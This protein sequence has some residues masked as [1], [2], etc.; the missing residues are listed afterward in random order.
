MKDLIGN[1]VKP[2]DILLEI[3]RGGSFGGGTSPSYSMKLWQKPSS[4]DGSGY[5]YDIDGTRSKFWW[6]SVHESI[7]IDMSTMPD[8]FEYSFKHG[9]S[10]LSSSIKNGTINELIETSNWNERRIIPS[11]VDGYLRK[12]ELKLSSIDDIKKNIG[13]LSD[14]NY[15]PREVMVQVMRLVGAK[16]APVHNGEIGLASMYDHFHYWAII[17]QFKKDTTLR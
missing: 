12:K 5:I 16:E 9:M 6:A 13:I 7:K 8:G 10:N 17:E 15:T 2:G 11:Q 4:N 14:N 1:T 3:G